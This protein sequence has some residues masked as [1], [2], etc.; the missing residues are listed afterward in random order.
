MSLIGSVA[1]FLHC[2]FILI[3]TGAKLSNSPFSLIFLFFSEIIPTALMITIF[4]NVSII[5]STVTSKSTS[6]AVSDSTENKTNSL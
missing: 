6:E 5:M 1:F 4:N 2:V 3:V